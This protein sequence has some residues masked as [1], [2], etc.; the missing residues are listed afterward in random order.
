[1]ETV[2]LS[3][4]DDDLVMMAAPA[5]AAV[6][7]S[8]ALV[9]SS[10]D[11]ETDAI[12]AQLAAVE[13]VDPRPQKLST[14]ETIQSMSVKDLRAHIGNL[15]A[16]PPGH[17][18]P[19]DKASMVELLSIS[20]GF[21]LLRTGSVSDP[22]TTLHLACVLLN[23]GY[24]T[25]KRAT[26]HSN[27]TAGSSWAKGTGFGGS[28]SRG[29]KNSSQAEAKAAERDKWVQ[30]REG[31]ALQALAGS[32]ALLSGELM[33]GVCAGLLKQFKVSENTSCQLLSKSPAA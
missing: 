10:D 27:S 32:V 16:L 4:D 24:R 3:S 11:D 13:A 21:N 22:L 1:M 26:G 19:A 14:G 12:T 6:H 8:E 30:E 28:D 15:G 2:V 29:G 17:S 33:V 20:E 25:R 9:L 7:A 31:V 18:N 23:A 5:E